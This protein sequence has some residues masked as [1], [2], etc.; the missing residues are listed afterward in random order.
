MFFDSKLVFLNV[1][2]GPIWIWSMLMQPA[3]HRGEIEMSHDWA[4]LD[5]V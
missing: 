2:P 3:Q 5:G 4:L 1:G